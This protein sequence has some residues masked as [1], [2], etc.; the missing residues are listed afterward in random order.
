[1]PKIFSDYTNRRIRFAL[2]MQKQE[3]R[4]DAVFFG[5][6]GAVLGFA[7][8]ALVRAQE[9]GVKVSLSAVN[10]L[11]SDFMSVKATLLILTL[12]ALTCSTRN[13]LARHHSVSIRLAK[14]AS[15]SAKRL[16]QLASSITCFSAGFG[17]GLFVTV[18]GSFDP[19]AL[20]LALLVFIVGVSASCFA[21]IGTA[22]QRDVG[23]LKESWASA[24]VAAGCIAYLC[25]ILAQGFN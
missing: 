4:V 25:R 1:M 9:K 12:V 7:A 22:V 17:F 5:T 18:L 24:I 8:N 3:L 14:I 21:V 6:V 15:H 13:L 11:L 2:E 16:R 23:A 19:Q 20:Y 10:D